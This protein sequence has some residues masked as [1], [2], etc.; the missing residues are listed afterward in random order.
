MLSREWHRDDVTDLNCLIARI[1]IEDGVASSDDLLVDANEEI[2][3]KTFKR[4]MWAG[5]VT[6]T[7]ELTTPVR[8][9]TV[10]GTEFDA[11]AT[12]GGASPVMSTAS[13]CDTLPRGRLVSAT[14]RPRVAAVLL[15]VLLLPWSL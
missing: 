2:D 8:V 11:P 14:P 1:G 7:V 6:A 13:N 15:V 12:P 10:R 4:P 5:N 3:E 9:C